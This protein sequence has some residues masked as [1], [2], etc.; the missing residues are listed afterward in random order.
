[1][2]TIDLPLFGY[3]VVMCDPPWP[4]ETYSA[5]GEAKSPTAQY[6]TMGF[7]EIDALRVGDLLAPGGILFLWCTW[8]LLVTGRQVETIRRWGLE[9]R[10]G[11]VWAKRTAAGKLRWGTGYLMRSCC[12]PFVLATL[13][14]SGFR[15]ASLPNLI[16]APGLSEA[17]TLIDATAEAALDGLAREH[18]RKPDE[19]YR[20]IEQATPGAR[21]ADVFARQRRPGWDGWGDELSKFGGEVA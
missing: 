14:A 7:A 10:T 4:W 9:P 3:D 13:P 20:L 5:A 2:T 15:G 11:G 6:R 17:P 21:R 12:E 16:E 1:M 19:V 18:S 8:P